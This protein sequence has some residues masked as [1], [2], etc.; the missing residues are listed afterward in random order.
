VLPFENMSGDPEQEFFSDGITTDIISTLS[1]FSHMR[2]VARHSTL[3]YK[4]QQASIAEIAEQQ[5]VRY[6]LEG[7]VRKSGNRIRVNAELIDSHSEQICW[8]EHYDHDLDD[9]FTAQD[10]M[11]KNIALAMKVHLDDGDMAMQRSTGTTNIKAWQ[12][13]LAAVDLQD[14]YIRENILEARAM[15]NE[16]IKLDPGYPYAWIALGWTHFQ[17]AYSGWCEAFDVPLAE[18]EKA[19][20]HALGIDSEY[21]EVWSQAGLIHVMKHEPE[22]ALKACRK[23][24]ELEP[25]NAEIQALMAFSLIF[26]GDYEQAR[27]HDH[28][29]LKLCPVLPNWYYLIGG[30][31]AQNTGSLDEAIRS[32]QLGIDVEPDSPLCRFYLIDAMMEQGDE[33]RAKIL[34]DEIRAL[35][36]TVTGKGLVRAVSHEKSIRDSFQVHL[37]K[38]DVF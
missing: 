31:I 25:G 26:A 17:E 7:S 34:A 9:L 38:F 28:N 15:A 19:N 13:T 6:I 36:Q 18:A 23:A 20:Q 35:D 12:L 37:E 8:S 30:Q 16:A 14:T 4:N 2:I 33:T 22:Q 24:V 32:Y 21:A 11:T 10:E 27:L 3:Q 1:K 5:D 29:M